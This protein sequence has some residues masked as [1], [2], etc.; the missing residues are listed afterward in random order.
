M[1][2][3]NARIGMKV[4]FGRRNGEKTLGVQ[5]SKVHH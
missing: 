1:L 5:R 2:R 4:L 3:E